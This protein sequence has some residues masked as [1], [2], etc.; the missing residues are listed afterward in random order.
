MNREITKGV[1]VAYS[2]QFLR[3]AAQFTGPLPFKR[4]VVTD[5]TDIGSGIVLATVAWDGDGVRPNRKRATATSSRVRTSILVR[6][7]QLHLEPA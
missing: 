2:R 3:D 6:E 1:R 5:L 4:G 7:D